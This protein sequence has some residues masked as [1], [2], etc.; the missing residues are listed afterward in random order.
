MKYATL[1]SSGAI[2]IAVHIGAG[3][4]LNIRVNILFAPNGGGLL[5][6]VVR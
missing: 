5:L 4:E 3:Q 2:S 1:S 6:S